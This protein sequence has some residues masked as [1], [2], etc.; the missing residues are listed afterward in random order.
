MVAC[1]GMTVV[2]LMSIVTTFQTASVNALRG[3][4]SLA[5]Y[6]EGFSVIDTIRT[7]DRNSNGKVDRSEITAFAE[8]HGLSVEEVIRDFDD[9]DTNG[10]GE[11]DV[12][13][14][15]LVLKG[16]ETG[17]SSKTKDVAESVVSQPV[18][19]APK[20]VTPQ[21]PAERLSEI[22]SADAK[23]KNQELMLDIQGLSRDAQLQADGVLAKSFANRA[24]QLLAQSQHDEKAASHYETVARSLRG[25][26]QALIQSADAETRKAA[27]DAMKKRS[28]AA[29][30]A[31]Q[32]LQAEAGHLKYEASE[33]R[34]LARQAMERVKNAEIDL[35]K[36]IK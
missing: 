11:L 16:A 10:D 33:H 2:A 15:A 9:I 27:S 29:S 7:F 22:V 35:A 23:G 26:M 1:V 17:T 6:L 32:Q 8:S 28:Q 31:V 24:Q 14:M 5:A 19:A 12:S 25:R 21:L 20:S 4:A 30:P 18:V 13:E 34:A 36:F 3:Q